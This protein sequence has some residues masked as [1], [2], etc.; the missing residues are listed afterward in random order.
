MQNHCS[1]RLAKM[2]KNAKTLLAGYGED[3]PAPHVKALPPFWRAGDNTHQSLQRVHLLTAVPG[4]YCEEIFK[5]VYRDLATSNFAKVKSW[6][7]PKCT[8]TVTIIKVH[9]YN[10][11]P[12]SH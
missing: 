8:K 9:L 1:I 12:H 4:F 6:K 11:I 3:P 5:D 2:T 10:G 7:Q